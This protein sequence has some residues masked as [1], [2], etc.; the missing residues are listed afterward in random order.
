MTKW[1]H[2]ITFSNRTLNPL[3]TDTDNLDTVEWW[4]LEEGLEINNWSP[5]Y[6]LKA[7]K[8]KNDGALED[9]LQ[10]HRGWLVYSLPLRD[11]LI[12]ANITGIQFLPIS[13]YRPNGEKLPPYFVVNILTVLPALDLSN[14]T[15]STYPPD[16]FLPA[17]RGKIS[18]IRKTAI[19]LDVAEGKDIFRLEEF[20]STV[21]VS[22]RFERVFADRFIGHEF[23]LL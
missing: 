18:G 9:Q 15:F 16:Y 4:H 22:E 23:T 11:A 17:K 21:I 1:Y 3:V 10:N 13:V 7:S 6:F 14:S 19:K 8:Q 2:L 12:S 5:S 20:K